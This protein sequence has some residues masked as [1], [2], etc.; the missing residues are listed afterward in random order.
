MNESDVPV[1]RFPLE[2]MIEFLESADVNEHGAEKWQGLKPKGF[3]PDN[4]C[5]Y[6]VSLAYLKAALNRADGVL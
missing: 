5:A 6:C 1:P 2:E 3:P 4:K